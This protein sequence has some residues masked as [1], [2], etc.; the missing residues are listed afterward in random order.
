MDT[1]NTN[2][3][4]STESTPAPVQHNSSPAQTFGD[5]VPNWVKASGLTAAHEAAGKAG[6]EPAKPA[7][8]T[9]PAAQ[10]P[11]KPSTIVPPTGQAPA[12]VSTA[13]PVTPTP[14]AFDETKLAQAIAQGIQRGQAPLPT[15]PSDAELAKQLGIFTATP[16]IYKSILGVEPTS[17]EQVTALNSALQGVAKQA[18]NISQV[19]QNQA[20]KE[21]EARFAPYISVIRT[22][23][24]TRVK[25]A[26]YKD[27]VD[28]TGYEPLVNQTYQAVLASGKQFA[29]V[30]EA[31]K[32]VAERTREMLKSAGV[33]PVIP[34]S[35]GAKPNTRT[36][37]PPARTMSPTSLGGRSG[38]SPATTP[39]KM[40]AVWGA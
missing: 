1:E 3:S 38:G 10:E 6:T 33:T 5:D 36:T 34:A 29:S 4:Q 14:A 2:S 16:E 9:P 26:F 20:M 19:L 23:E 40:S 35:P 32:F 11:A 17:A 37:T 7:T 22:N 24:A 27:N 31:G 15:G 21:L 25:E 13:Q 18:V 12:V 8:I 28:L 30:E 39:T